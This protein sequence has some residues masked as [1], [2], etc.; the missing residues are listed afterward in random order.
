MSVTA[1]VFQKAQTIFLP[2]LHQG[3]YSGLMVS[4]PEASDKA[5]ISR[6][7]FKKDIRRLSN[8]YNFNTNK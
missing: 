5:A 8:T 3:D 2:N 1:L 7:I 4:F 6:N